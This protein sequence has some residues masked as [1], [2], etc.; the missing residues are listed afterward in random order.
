VVGEG[1]DIMVLNFNDDLSPFY[2]FIPG[3]FDEFGNCI[4][5]D[6][7]E[8]YIVLGN[9]INEQTGK[10][11][12][13]LNF[14]EADSASIKSWEFMTTIPE[15]DSDLYAE[16]IIK[17]KGVGNFAIVGTRVSNNNSDIFLQFLHNWQAEPNRII[18]GA[19]GDQTGADIVVAGDGGL[20][21]AGSNKYGENSMIT[22]IKTDESG[23]F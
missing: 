14:I 20:I 13:L 21:I 8:R 3:N 9:R 2:K 5:Q 19:T 6:T 17:T 15:I 10:S 12:I 11:E 23:N 16:R 7:A 18:F 1:T 4:V 22:L